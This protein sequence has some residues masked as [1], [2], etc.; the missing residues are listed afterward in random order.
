MAKRPTHR[1]PKDVRAAI[2]SAGVDGDYRARPPYQRND[3]VGWVDAAK[4]EATRKRRIA[5]MV[6][7]LKRGGV[8]MGMTHRPSAKG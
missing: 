3:Y 5:K 2:G 4:S 6:D 8:Y 7:E 1:M